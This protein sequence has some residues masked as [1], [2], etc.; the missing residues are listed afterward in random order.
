[1]MRVFVAVQVSD[2][3]V[4]DSIKNIQEDLQIRAKAV[5]LQNMHFTLQFLGEVS[6]ETVEKVKASLKGITFLPFELEIC[7]VGVFPD[8][9]RPRVIWVGTKD[10]MA[11][12]KLAEKVENSLLPLGFKCDKIFKPHLTIF[13]NK[14]KLGNIKKDLDRFAEYEFGK[15][16]VSEIKLVE[17][18]L[19]QTGPIYSDVEV[20]SAQ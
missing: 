17:S 20:I 6:A 5:Q 1:M 16:T 14:N 9:K 10:S 7:G 15:I 13:R 19:T 8:P 3:E 18:K 2:K 4:L 12:I 11:L